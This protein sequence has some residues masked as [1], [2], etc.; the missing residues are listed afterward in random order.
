MVRN[1]TCRLSHVPIVHLCL[2]NS[3]NSILTLGRESLLH[4]IE[5]F[6][7]GSDLLSVLLLF[8]RTAF[9]YSLGLKY[10]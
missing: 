5:V 6:P 4:R 2:R 1:L 8:H 7:E 10:Q 9:L 3:K